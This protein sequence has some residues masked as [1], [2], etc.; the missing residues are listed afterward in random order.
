[1]ARGVQGNYC[2]L[3]ATTL[4]LTWTLADR[5]RYVCYEAIVTIV[6]NHYRMLNDAEELDARKTLT[7]ALM[8][9]SLLKA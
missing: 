4:T 5:N 1:M 9:L 3:N 2:E 8:E 7:T 6:I